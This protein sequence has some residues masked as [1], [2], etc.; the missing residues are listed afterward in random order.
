MVVTRLEH[1]EILADGFGR[2]EAGKYFKAPVDLD[3]REAI[4]LGAYDDYAVW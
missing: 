3:Q 4:L 2:G 1:P